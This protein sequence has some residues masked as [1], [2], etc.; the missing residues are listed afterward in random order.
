MKVYIVYG[1]SF[2]V[3][4]NTNFTYSNLIMSHNYAVFYNRE[5]AVKYIEMAWP[6]AKL[7]TDYVTRNFWIERIKYESR[8]KPGVYFTCETYYGI[9]EKELA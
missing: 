3:D 4:P 8:I 2:G 6:N 5:D 9:D 1:D 7:G